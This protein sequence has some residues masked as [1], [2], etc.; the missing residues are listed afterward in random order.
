V[1]KTKDE[2]NTIVSNDSIGDP[3]APVLIKVTAPVRWMERSGVALNEGTQHYVPRLTAAEWIWRELCEPVGWTPTLDE[4]RAG[5]VLALNSDEATCRNRGAKPENYYQ[6][7]AVA[8]RYDRMLARATALNAR[9]I[10]LTGDDDP[11][12][13]AA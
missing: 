11:G 12:G 13:R 6:L 2:I 9:A 10:E 5:L 3:D 1:T 7:P 8:R 4:W